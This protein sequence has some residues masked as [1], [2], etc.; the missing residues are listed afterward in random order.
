M[1][2]RLEAIV[3]HSIVKVGRP[4]MTHL[5]VEGGRTLSG[6][7]DV[8]SSKNAGVALLCASLIN[9]GTTTLRR[10]A[11][12]EEVNRIVEVLTSIGVECTWL[13]AND[14]QIRRP[15]VL[16]LDSMDVEA[17][18]R[19]RSVIMLLGPLLDE[20][21]RV[22]AALRGRLR[23]RHPHRGAAHAGAAP[24]RPH[25]RGQ[26][27]FLRCPGAA[28]GRARPLLRAQRT[29]R[30]RHRERHHGRGPPPRH[31]HHPQRQPQLHGAGSL[32]LP[33]DAR[34]GNRRALAPPR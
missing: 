31:H 25:R 9:R 15:A 20:S 4:Q 33:A 14:L 6:A 22:P 32:L 11:R 1:I 27:R 5:R 24:V 13:N 18:R 2:Q 23:P 17:A 26:V 8:N 21:S 28:V 3:G 30:H 19:T 7:V 12:I 29:R 16:D 10:L 34:R